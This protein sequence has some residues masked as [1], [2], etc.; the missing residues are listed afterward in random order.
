MLLLGNGGACDFYF[1][2]LQVKSYNIIASL[3]LSRGLRIG[4]FC[5]WL[6]N[7]GELDDCFLPA[8]RWLQ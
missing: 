2:N 5:F 6:S 3:S 1:A 4:I 8:R 7:V